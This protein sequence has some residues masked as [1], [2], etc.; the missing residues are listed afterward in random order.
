[1]SRDLRIDQSATSI[2]NLLNTNGASFFDDVKRKIGPLDF[3][4]SYYP[5]LALCA[6]ILTRGPFNNYVDKM[7]GWGRGTRGQIMYVFVHPQGPRRGGRGDKKMAK[8]T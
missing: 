2:Q 1:M 4:H 3:N 8:F 7:R 6:R 5:I